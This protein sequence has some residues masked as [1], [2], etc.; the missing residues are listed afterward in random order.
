[1][2]GEGNL[3]SFVQVIIAGEIDLTVIFFSVFNLRFQKDSLL[4]ILLL[5]EFIVRSFNWY[6][7]SYIYRVFVFY[8]YV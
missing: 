3:R 1:M 2:L 5:E 8:D 7:K 4:I 6:G